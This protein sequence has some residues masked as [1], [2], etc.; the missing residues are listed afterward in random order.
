M[1]ARFNIRHWQRAA[2]V[3]VVAGAAFW[4]WTR[5]E[6]KA[7]PS[8][9]PVI[10]RP[11]NPIAVEYARAFQN[12]A[13]DRIIQRTCWMQE[14]LVHAQ[15]EGGTPAARDTAMAQLRERLSDRRIEGN[16]LR[17]EGV[18]DQYV[19]TR[20]ADIEPLGADEGGAT[21]E[22]AT[23]DRTWFRVAYPSPATALRD[24]EGQP[25]HALTV[26]VSVS[27][28]GLV[29]KAGVIGN[30]DIDP[31]TIDYWNAEDAAE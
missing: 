17:P 25:I 29:L 30:L 26:G 9:G 20:D 18:E 14:R 16:R 27:E 13:W 5:P 31:L 10:T 1:N 3:A 28:D 24:E 4:W 22:R 2:L 8:R 12:D 11:A 23:K 21:L 15:V 7:A 19:F 6:P